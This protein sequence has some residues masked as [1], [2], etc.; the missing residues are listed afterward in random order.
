M[1]CTRTEQGGTCTLV[2]G[3]TLD[4]SE[5]SHVRVLEC[6]L[7]WVKLVS[8]VAIAPDFQHG[9]GREVLCTIRLL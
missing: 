2:F 8:G 1:E 7:F 9:V 4:S 5:L 6:R 3:Q